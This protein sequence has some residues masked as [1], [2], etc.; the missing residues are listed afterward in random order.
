MEAG[1]QMRF[2]QWGGK[3][4]EQGFFWLF[5]LLLFSVV[6]SSFTPGSDVPLTILTRGLQ[7]LFTYIH[8]GCI[9]FW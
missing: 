6:S 2:R 9:R 1:G 3:G 8:T 5:F 4:S 7:V